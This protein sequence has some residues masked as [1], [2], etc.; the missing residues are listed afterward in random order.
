MT[1]QE[2][3][4]KGL[5]DAYAR[6]KGVSPYALFENLNGTDELILTPAEALRM[7]APKPKQ[8]PK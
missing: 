2:C 3:C 7:V 8:D 6:L 5:V 4:D 1:W